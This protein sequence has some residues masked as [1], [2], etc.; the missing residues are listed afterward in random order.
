MWTTGRIDVQGR[1]NGIHCKETLFFITSNDKDIGLFGFSSNVL[2]FELTILH[3]V[4][5]EMSKKT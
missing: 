4:G 3:Y 2:P 1:K 5:K